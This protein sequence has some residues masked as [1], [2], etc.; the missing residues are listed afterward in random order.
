[1]NIREEQEKREHLIF[2]PYASFSDESRGRDRDEEPCPMRTIYQRDR[3]RIIHCKTFRRLKH[4][5][6]VFLAPEGDHYRTRLTHTLE[7]AQIARSIARALNLNEDLTEAIALGHDLGHT[8]FGHAGE[9]TLNSLCPM[10]FAHYKQSIRVVEF[11]EKDGQGLN[12]TWEVRDGILNHRTSGNPSTLEGKAVRLS[13][14]IA[15]INH[16]IDDGIRAGILKESDIPLEYTDVLGNS[17]K[18]RLNTMI[19]DII[20]NSIGKNNLVMSEP[21]HKAMTDL[22]KFMFESLYLN[23]TAKSEEAKADKLITE[24][25]R[26]YVANTDKLPDTYKRFITEFDERPEQVVCDYIAG[27]SDQYS[28]SKFQEIF[29]PKAWKG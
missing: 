12:L 20:M 2:S 9:R 26:Y 6:Q 3:D 27:M 17:T 29:V 5:T 16:D 4:K 10:G 23:P 14:K 8:P 1:M 7:V 21:V 18:E 22:R 13:D 11:L 15:Y 28:I 25:Y 19:S 24:L